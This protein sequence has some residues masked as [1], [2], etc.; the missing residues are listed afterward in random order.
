MTS[1]QAKG[2][3]TDTDDPV[4]DTDVDT[5]TDADEE[6]ADDIDTDVDSGPV[7]SDDEGGTSSGT[8]DLA[9]GWFSALRR[10]ITREQLRGRAVPFVAATV[11]VASVAAA[12]TSYVTVFRE[13]EATDTEAVSEVVGAA[14]DG[15]IAIL[16]YSPKTLD[17]D[18]DRAK[19]HLT[20]QF[21]TY[22]QQFTDKVVKPAATRNGIT[23]TATVV[24]SAVSSISADHAEVLAFVN[25]STVSRVKP[26]AEDSSSS[27]RVSLQK[28]DGTWRIS[29]F[30]PV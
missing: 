8:G 6:A 7:A 20:G 16:S 15:T 29:N 30:D 4:V 22:Y 27:V 5:V 18:F 17:A 14:K 25:Q 24:R 21:L 28:V 13:D 11:M 19:S 9:A 26:D 3:D 23:T 12:V 2:T 10:H 1:E